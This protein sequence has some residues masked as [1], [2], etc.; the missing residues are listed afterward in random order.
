MKK[1][2]EAYVI[3]G[4]SLVGVAAAYEALLAHYGK[5][6]STICNLGE[7]FSC[8]IVN[9]STYSAIFG[10]PFALLGIIGYASMLA[11][12]IALIVRKSHKERE[13]LF[14]ALCGLASIGLGIQVYLTLVELLFIHVWCLMCLISQVSILT[15]TVTAWIWRQKNL[16]NIHA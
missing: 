10:I 1:Q 8:D 6:N 7:S 11:L 4:F 12:V 13:I 9:Q 14:G 3:G 2:I 15:V 5:A 16:K